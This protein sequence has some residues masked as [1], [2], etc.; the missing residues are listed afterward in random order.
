MTKQYTFVANWKMYLSFD[1]SIKYVTD[2]I[3]KIIACLNEILL[4][5]VPWFFIISERIDQRGWHGIKPRI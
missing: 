2:N 3:D 4:I 1:E 5:I